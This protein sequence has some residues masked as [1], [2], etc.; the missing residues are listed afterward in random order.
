[1]GCLCGHSDLLVFSRSKALANASLID[2]NFS[3]SQLQITNFTNANLTNAN[4][5]N[6]HIAHS[7]FFNANCTDANLCVKRIGNVDFQQVNLKD[8]KL[9]KE[10]NEPEKYLIELK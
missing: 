10:F 7:V 8:T 4:F 1:M 6:A 9:S 3:N 2:A 5:T